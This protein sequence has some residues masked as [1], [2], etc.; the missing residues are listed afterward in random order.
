MTVDGYKTNAYIYDSSIG[1]LTFNNAPESGARIEVTD[2]SQEQW[3]TDVYI[4]FDNLAQQIQVSYSADDIKTVL[5]VKGQDDFNIREVNMGLDYITDLSFYYTVDW[6]GQDLYDAYTKY[7]TLCNSSRATYTQNA[8]EMLLIADEI[9]YL[10]NRLSLEYSEADFVDATTVGTYYVRGGESGNYYYTEVSLPMDYI[11]ETQYYTLSGNDLTEEK[12]SDLYMALRSYF[13]T[14]SLTELDALSD[15]FSFMD[16]PHTIAELSV[17]LSGATTIEDKDSLILDFLDVMWEQYGQFMLESY[18]TYFN[19]IQSVNTEWSNINHENYGFWYAS[20]LMLTSVDRE[21][22]DRQEQIQELQDQYKNMQNTNVDISNTLLMQNNF[23]EGQL[24]RLSAF[25]REDEYSDDQFAETSQD[26]IA[27][28]FKLKQELL[29]CGQIELNKLCQP[30][31]AFSMSMAN[32]YALPEFA[33]IM[34]QFQLGKLIKVGLRSDYI[35]R[36]RL[37]QVNINFENFD[38]FSCEFGE[39]TSL[40]NPS[41]IHA[42][43]LSQA[44]SA[45]KSVA[46]NAS[47]WDKGTEQATET[48]LKIQQGLLDAATAIK[49]IDGTQNVSIDQYGIHLQKVNSVTGEVDPKQGWIVNNQFLYSDDGFKTT[50]SVFGEFGDGQWGLLAEA[51]IAGYIEG[52]TMVGGTIDIGNGS[53]KVDE[54][55]NVTMNGGVTLPGNGKMIYTSRPDTYQVDDIWILNDGEVCGSF[56]AGSVLRATVDSSSFNESHWQD[57]QSATTETLTNVRESF[58]W[59]ADGIQV[60]K[61]VVDNEGNASKPFYVQIESERMGFHSVSKDSGDVEVVHIG[62][63]SATIK[64]ATLEGEKGAT[65]NTHAEFNNITEFHDRVDICQTQEINGEEQISGFR[66]Q[67]ESNGSFSFVVIE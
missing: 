10:Q 7:L 43:L 16:S 38:D 30:T 25:L 57:A 3:E 53:F 19:E 46:S 54:Y 42:D 9:W 21:I 4:T 31:L 14:G 48:D 39:L 62:N 34:H 51:V 50:K 66:S 40:R 44:V 29:E 61:T 58:T 24:I 65:F 12:I 5:T 56:G 60:A 11:A 63:N 8:Q 32:I 59:N 13:K 41:D 17:G 15:D 28:I 52:S 67:I 2:G 6:M 20:Y 64:N 18:K 27:D 55:G 26:S 33:P 35:K 47:Y 36:S 1:A 22:S 23:T 37:M 49:S 45:G